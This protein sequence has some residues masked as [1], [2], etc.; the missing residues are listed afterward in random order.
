MKGEILLADA[1]EDKTF[2]NINAWLK[3]IATVFFDKDAY[4]S[5]QLKGDVEGTS[6]P[7][8]IAQT[9]AKLKEFGIYIKPKKVWTLNVK[10][11]Y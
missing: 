9:E 6:D 8:L 1:F 3:V 2:H 10:E 11:V 7:Q 4:G 5:Y